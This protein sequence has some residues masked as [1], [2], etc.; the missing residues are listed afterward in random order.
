MTPTERLLRRLQVEHG[1]EVPT[2]WTFHR[3]RAGWIQRSQG[4][5]S[6]FILDPTGR[7]EILA[8]HWSVGALLREPAWVVSRSS[9]VPTPPL[10]IDPAA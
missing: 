6:W 9:I 2:G 1:V 7:H 8:S 3:T 10:E 5:W 4:A